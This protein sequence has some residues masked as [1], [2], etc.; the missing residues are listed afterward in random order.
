MEINLTESEARIIISALKFKKNRMQQRIRWW[1]KRAE[2]NKVENVKEM[3]KL[4][5]KDTDTIENHIEP[6]IERVAK[7]LN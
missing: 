1:H 3:E 5:R 4:N 2:D 6:L 7:T